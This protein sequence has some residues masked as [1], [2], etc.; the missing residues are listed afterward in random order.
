[1]F[2]LAHEHTDGEDCFNT[3]NGKYKL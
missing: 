1:M 2:T 3:S